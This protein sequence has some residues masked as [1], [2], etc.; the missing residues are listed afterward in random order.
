L[1]DATGRA[2]RQAVIDAGWRIIRAIS[3]IA[4]AALSHQRLLV[5]EPPGGQAAI[6]VRF[7]M[8][9]TVT[10]GPK[11]PKLTVVVVF[12]RGEDGELTGS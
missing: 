10:P 7:E 5:G 4:A 3:V 6:L 12:D 11:S 1:R 2:I 9:E 8:V